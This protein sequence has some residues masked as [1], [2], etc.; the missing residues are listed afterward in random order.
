MQNPG[1]FPEGPELVGFLGLK[2]QGCRFVPL[3]TF[4][5][6]PRWKVVEPGSG[7]LIQGQIYNPEIGSF[8]RSLRFYVLS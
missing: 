8:Q 4:G 2:I 6:N 1:W 5:N 7:G 3:N